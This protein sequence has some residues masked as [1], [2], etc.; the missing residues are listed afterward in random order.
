[1]TG[2]QRRTDLPR[3]HRRWAEER[4]PL[5]E[6]VEPP[7][8]PELRVGR[9]EGAGGT[10]QSGPGWT[11]RGDTRGGERAASGSERSGG[12][13]THHGLGPGGGRAQRWPAAG[14]AQCPGKSSPPPARPPRAASLGFAPGLGSREPRTP[15]FAVSPPGSER[16]ERGWMPLGAQ[17]CRSLPSAGRLLPTASNFQPPSLSAVGPPA[18]GVPSLPPGPAA[19]R[20]LEHPLRPGPQSPL[21]S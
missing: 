18:G 1:M 19:G 8:S 5:S 13:R 3:H 16:G 4:V 12:G 14:L 20:Q 17:G 15:L 7:E 2:A 11:V 10:R 9:Q 6:R 21:L